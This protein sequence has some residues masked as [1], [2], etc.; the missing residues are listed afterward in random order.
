LVGLE[1]GVVVYPNFELELLA[2]IHNII[3]L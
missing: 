1:G 3:D 2:G